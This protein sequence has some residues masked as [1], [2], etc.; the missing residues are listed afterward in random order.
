[1]YKKALYLSLLLSASPIT[2]ADNFYQNNSNTNQSHHE[3]T[4]GGIGLV[5]GTLAAGPLGAIIG[6]SLGVMNGHQQA[7]G[8]LITQQDLT[9][10]QLEQEL[11]LQM[12]SLAQH[13][14]Q[15]TTTKEHFQISQ[16]S[17]QKLETEQQQSKQK[18]R[19]DLINFAN[20]YQFDV[21]FM[22]N[23]TLVSDH[24]QQGLLKLASLLTNNQHIHANIEAHSDWR[25]SDDVNNLLA[26]KRLTAISQQLIQAGSRQEQLLTTNYGEY[27][28]INQGSWG[29]ELF[30]DRRVTITLSYFH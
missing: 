22:T 3:V 11:T 19:G 25:G 12:T 9:I 18:H 28:N 10:S 7:Q 29:E 2:M 24:S 6:G 8:E 4:S 1:M 26:E 17:V 15:L 13:K 20:S 27:S 21:Y 23:S 14:Q 16:K 30:Y 5:I